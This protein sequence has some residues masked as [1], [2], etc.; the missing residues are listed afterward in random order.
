MNWLMMLTTEMGSWVQLGPQLAGL[1][2]W[3]SVVERDMGSSV[4]IGYGHGGRIVGLGQET[5]QILGCF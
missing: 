4:G 1:Q 5:M 2:P 3:V